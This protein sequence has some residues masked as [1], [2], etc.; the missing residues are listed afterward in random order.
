MEP[1]SNKII[2][3]YTNT[4]S[5]NIDV[6]NININCWWHRNIWVLTCSY[7]SC[8]GPGVPL[9]HKASLCINTSAPPVPSSP[10]RAILVNCR[11]QMKK[12]GEKERESWDGVCGGR[13]LFI[14]SLFLNHALF[15]VVTFYVFFSGCR[16]AEAGM[17]IKSVRAC[18]AVFVSGSVCVHL[19][20][21]VR[22][23][24]IGVERACVNVCVC[25][26]ALWGSAEHQCAV[27]AGLAVQHVEQARTRIHREGERLPQPTHKTTHTKHKTQQQITLISSTHNHFLSF[28]CLPHKE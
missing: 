22:W 17:Q 25:V 14:Y 5:I 9:S 21:Y 4:N 12:E 3:Y 28:S 1:T 8:S 24:R 10:Q 7:E 15:F 11:K 18:L 20:V 2:L 6:I 26:Q 16:E 23:I 13:L 27:L 19:P